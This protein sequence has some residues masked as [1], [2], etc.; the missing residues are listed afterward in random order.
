MKL[1]FTKMQGIGNDFVVIDGF[2]QPIQLSS[3]QIRQ[4]ADRHFGIGCDQLLLVEKPTVPQAE[5]RYRIFNADGGE[6]E[7]CG[8]GARCFVKFVHDKKL[9]GNTEICVETARGL[10]YPKLED[11][12]QVTVNMGAPRFTPSEIPFVAN[13]LQP[14]YALPLPT[15]LVTIAVASMGNPHAVQI[16]DNVDTAPVETDGPLIE[17]HPQFPQ[18]VNAGFMQIIDP[19][20]IRLRVFERGSGETLACGTGACAAVVSGIRL[21]HLQSPVRVSTRGGELT[22]QWQGYHQPVWMTGPA[23]TVFDGE[24]NLDNLSDSAPAK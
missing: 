4:L 23:A 19:H 3:S 1:R 11:N 21:G 9:T 18:R 5:F 6:V 24:I 15:K 22:I 7:Q 13:G 17:S 10:I 20:H 8:N 16:V 14:T 12:G 2:S